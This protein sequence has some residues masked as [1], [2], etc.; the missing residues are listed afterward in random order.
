[1][2]FSLARA[3]AAMGAYYRGEQLNLQMEQDKANLEQTRLKSEFE[4]D[5]LAQERQQQQQKQ[6]SAQQLQKLFAAAKDSNN[7]QAVGASQAA[8]IYSKAAD[9]AASRGDFDGANELSKLA[10]GDEERAKEEAQAAAGRTQQYKEDAAHIAM[11]IAQSDTAGNPTPEQTRKLTM[12]AINA[13]IPMKD[14]PHDPVGFAAFAKNAQ[15]MAMTS[16]EAQAAR[17]KA[18]EFQQASQQKLE[19]FKEREET[20]RLAMQQNALLRES[21]LDLE[22]ERIEIAKDKAA[23][24][25]GG[26]AI[27]ARQT[28]AAVNY[29]NEVVR[30]LGT[31][32]N[33]PAGTTTGVFAHLENPET[34]L[35]AVAKSGANKVTPQ[36][37]QQL[38][39][40]GAGLGLEMAQIATVGSG[41]GANQAVIAEFQK[42][43][44]PQKGDT[45]AT[46]MFRI[47]NAAD[48]VRTRLES[49]AEPTDPKLKAI[50]D[51]TMKELSRYPSPTAIID[52]ARKA[53]HPIPAASLSHLNETY[54]N[55]LSRMA[56]Q[57]SHG[58]VTLDEGAALV[59]KYTK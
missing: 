16:K 50:Y 38:N 22:R 43:V 5:A 32:T 19:E 44:V 49:V 25:P 27:E 59:D 46:A 18:M 48:F 13:G 54:T 45:E 26:G 39:V 33:M 12:A 47:A 15:T 56:D 42:M 24:P 29:G 52:E 35:G 31:L 36:L 28:R 41:R 37:E 20:R 21:M 51:R 58:S 55:A 2:A 10:K 30:G 8:Q 4:K 6:Q 53:G 57:E 17:E 34:I 3:S 1:M 7:G 14:I 40:A 23:K 11:E 9:E